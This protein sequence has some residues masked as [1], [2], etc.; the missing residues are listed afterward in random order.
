M[1]Q[2]RG[3][4]QRIAFRIR[5]QQF[6][7]LRSGDGWS[8]ALVFGVRHGCIP[9]I[10]QDGIDMPFERV[11]PG[12]FLGDPPYRPEPLAGDGD[13]SAAAAAAAAVP[14]LDY[15]TFAIRVAEEDIERTGDIL[16]VVSD[17][18]VR[19]LQE[20]LRRVRRLFAYDF[21]EFPGEGPP[22][23]PRPGTRGGRRGGGVAAF[24]VNDGSEDTQSGAG[25]FGL[26]GG[27]GGA[28]DRR[29][30]QPWDA[31]EMIMATLRR[32]LELRE[33]AKAARRTKRL[34]PMTKF[35]APPSQ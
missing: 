34:Q 21:P 17:A 19:R 6:V 32:K 7:L 18:E 20:G 33:R 11:G 10:I 25:G 35:T 29:V 2:H 28:A 23:R 15:S 9:V 5:Q 27:G 24:G 4:F 13:V 22:R 14:V 26:G 30:D 12:V 1:M 3:G 31:M 16:S 8:G